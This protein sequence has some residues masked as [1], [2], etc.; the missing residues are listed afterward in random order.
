MI[1]TTDTET[2]EK[3]RDGYYYP[4]LGANNY[5]IG[6]IYYE[7]G[8]SESFTN[9]E[10]HWK[11]IKELTIQESKKNKP[12]YIYAHNHQYDLIA[13]AG[14]QP[15][16]NNEI[17]IICEK[18]LLAKMS[19]KTYLLDTLS[20]FRLTLEEIGQLIKEPKGK[21][22]KKIKDPKELIPYCTQDCKVTMQ[23]IKYIQKTLAEVGFKPRKLLTAGQ[24]AISTWLTHIRKTN[25][26]KGIM[27]NG[28]IHKSPNWQKTKVAHRGGH[29]QAYKKGT[30][31]N[32]TQLDYKGFYANIMR[33]MKFPNLQKYKLINNPKQE[34]YQDIIQTIGITQAT[35]QIHVPEN[36][37]PFLPIR[38]DKTQYRPKKATVKGTW[39]N[40][41]LQYAQQLKQITIQTIHW[42]EIYEESKTNP[43]K[44]YIDKLE[45]IETTQPEKKPIIKILRNNLYGKFGQTR[46]TKETKFI[47][48]ADLE[49]YKR[50]NWKVK[51]IVENLYYIEKEGEPYIPN[52]TNPIISTMITAEG[53]I[54][55]H[56]T[57]KTEIYLCNTDGFT[58]NTKD[59]KHYKKLIGNK[60]GQIKIEEQGTITIRGEGDYKIG[61]KEVRNGIPLINRKTRGQRTTMI[62][63][64]QA[65]ERHQ[66][67]RLGE[68][69]TDKIR[70]DNNK[71]PTNTLPDYIDET[72]EYY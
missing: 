32:C 6:V 29:I 58:I 43:F 70:I 17:N 18:P 42:T 23:S 16:L 8:T 24:I 35:I 4:K 60:Y 44:T 33:T 21:M 46:T 5:T 30:Y 61:K 40:H 14:K 48:R 26:Y 64:H 38:Y 56:K 37:I 22:P 71:K 28:K 54:Q 9:K 68:F 49:Q 62:T 65:I 13:Y 39:T 66:M 15:I 50:Q 19:Q 53:R 1:I 2:Y 25:Q 41:E 20:F 34:Q 10:D 59:L 57:F 63:I 69:I 36:H 51:D 31:K 3:R 55:L 27:W 47:T 67:N 45:Q 7:N 12:L 11:R 52:Y 72:K